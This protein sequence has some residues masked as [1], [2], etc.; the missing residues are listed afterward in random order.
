MKNLKKLLIVFFFTVA[1][2]LFVFAISASAEEVTY[3]VDGGYIYFD[4]DYQEITR[5]TSNIKNLTIPSTIEGVRVTSIATHAFYGSSIESLYI[6]KSV[7]NIG[8]LAFA[9]CNNLLSVEINAGV[10]ALYDTFWNC[11]SLKEVRITNGIPTLGATFMGCRSLESVTLPKG[12]QEILSCTFAQTAIKAITLPASVKTIEYDAFEETPLEKITVDSNNTTFTSNDGILFSK[13]MKTLIMYPAGRADTIY[14]IP[15]NVLG[16]SNHAFY[17]LFNLK[18]LVVSPNF[19]SFDSDDFSSSIDTIYYTCTQE[20]WEFSGHGSFPGYIKNHIYS[21]PCS[22]YGHN[23]SEWIEETAS[24][25]FSTGSEYRTC[26]ICK[27][28]QTMEI[29]QISHS[30]G[31][32][33]VIAPPTETFVGSQIRVCSICSFSEFDDIPAIEIENDPSISVDGLAITVR[34]LD[35]VKDFFIAKGVHNT[36]REVKNNSVMRVTE[37]RINGENEYTYTVNQPGDYT[38]CIRF[39]DGSENLILYAT[40]TAELPELA[41]KGLA[42]VVDGL[43]DVRVIRTAP[44]VWNSPA[45]VK[46]AAGCRSITANTIGNTDS[47]TVYYPES[48]TYT[49]TLEYTNGLVVV[50]H[51]ELNSTIPTLVQDGNSVTIGNLDNLYTIRYAKGEYATMGEIKRADGCQVRRSRNIVDGV[52]TVTDLEPGTYTFC[53]QYNDQ[54]YNYFTVVVE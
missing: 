28:T 45:E 9:S 40:V 18:A 38:I 20:E 37:A 8:S 47:Y 29:A 7:T 31:D 53:V 24:T 6:P 22:V 11:K 52:I 42:L 48:G 34:N 15:T 33:M 23:W 17:Y 10:N 4:T 46:R 44:G 16:L 41:T 25:C 21:Y 3:P 49:V 27:T 39:N 43:K 5:G 26:T 50:E 30:F 1:V 36:Y 54:S 19:V 14:T 51:I 2:S 35:G 13:D 12:V 32:W